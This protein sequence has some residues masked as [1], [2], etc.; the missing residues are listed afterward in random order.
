MEKILADNGLAEYSKLLLEQGFDDPA[1]LGQIEQ[2]FEDLKIKLG[3][4]AKFKQLAIQFDPKFDYANNK[5]D[6]PNGKEHCKGE[7]V[8]ICTKRALLEAGYDMHDFKVI[9]HKIS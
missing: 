9:V 3:H 4:R 8:F 1:Q 5:E 6:N 7:I 2:Y